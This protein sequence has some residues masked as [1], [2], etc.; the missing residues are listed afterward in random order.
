MII[1]DEEF[2]EAL[3]TRAQNSGRLRAHHCLHQSHQEPVQRLVIAL[4]KNSYIPPHKHVLPHHWEY[5]H[6]IDGLIK[7]ISFS[8]SGQ[9]DSIKLLGNDTGTFGVQIPTNVIHTL[10][11]L[12]S[13][14]MVFEL[15]EG[16]FF[17][18][19]A[20]AFPSWSVMED[21]PAAHETVIRLENIQPGEFLV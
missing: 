11:C 6:V 12:S 10:V 15:K 8:E 14:A 3:Y 13:K 21:E 9:V 2:K 5:F 7:L 4:M 1:L 16:P 17:E 20:K 19:H 18:S